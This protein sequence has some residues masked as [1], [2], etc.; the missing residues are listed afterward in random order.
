V[1]DIKPIEV[2]RPLGDSPP[3]ATLFYG[4]SCLKTLRKLADGSVH[5]AV[6]SPPY[7]GLRDYDGEPQNW[8]GDADCD[9][10][11]KD[12]EDA[13]SGQFCQQCDAWLG[14][15]GLEPTPQLFVAHLVEV[16]REL[17]RVL[18]DDGTFW[19]NLGD[20]YAGSHGLEGSDFKPKDLVGIPWRATR[21]QKACGIA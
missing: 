2:H 19:L 6:T 1:S 15:F 7:W 18:R 3:T 21:C 12:A 14:Q 11:W 9:H 4:A 8:G 16:F 10:E 17:R 20:S 5:C 13:G